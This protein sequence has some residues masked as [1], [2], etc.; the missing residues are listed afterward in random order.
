MRV[1]TTSAPL[2][3][4]LA[5][6]QPDNCAQTFEV[7]DTGGAPSNFVLTQTLYVDQNAPAG[8]D[9]SI[10][11]PFNTWAAA[12]AAA[13]GPVLGVA[14]P[15]VLLL[16]PGDYTAEG[17]VSVT[18]KRLT[19][20]G[21][22]LLNLSGVTATHGIFLELHST[23]DV[24]LSAELIG[25]NSQFR[26]KS[27]NLSVIMQNAYCEQ[28]GDG[29]H[30]ATIIMSGP[31]P[32]LN[33]SVGDGPNP[34]AAN[35]VIDGGS[36]GSMLIHGSANV[37]NGTIDGSGVILENIS[38]AESVFS[39]TLLQ[40]GPI[41][42]HHP[43]KMWGCFFP[44]DAT[45]VVITTPDNG[46]VYTDLATYVR[47]TLSGVTWPINTVLVEQLTVTPFRVNDGGGTNQNVNATAA[48]GTN[49]L[50]D[51]FVAELTIVGANTP[52]ALGGWTLIGT[53]STGSTKKY[54]FMRD[55]QSAGGEA[56]SVTWTIAAGNFNNQLKIH[57]FR[58]V[59]AG[60]A[61]VACENITTTTS[62]DPG[63]VIAGPTVTP[64][65]EGRLA[66]C[67]SGSN[68]SS[69]T[70]TE[71]TGQAGATWVDRG[72]FQSGVAGTS[73]LQTAA[74]AD[75]Q[76]VSGGSMTMPVGGITQ[77]IARVAF[78]LIGTVP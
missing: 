24:P 1:L 20:D 4:K 21:R 73:N 12:A 45:S 41:E 2:G 39:N 29:T 11:A 23:G 50:G 44:V 78:A 9:G 49:I 53:S 6:V 76:A 5:L 33:R 63:G 17:V 60:G 64:V 65:A 51:T 47:G 58:H 36:I 55:T 56:G 77:E 14:Q 30:S 35:W 19:I 57:T 62:T 10:A 18:D 69:G 61:G 71:I 22:G 38:A 66:C 75:A 32:L 68:G 54:T 70:P 42:T 16:S 34:E 48:Y 3:A 8:G 52:A 27:H 28:H 43:L 46:V 72:S 13:P 40:S 59:I 74:L 37:R 25:I 67:F 15:C 31:M 26:P 7:Q